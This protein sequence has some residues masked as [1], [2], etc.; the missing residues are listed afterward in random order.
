MPLG[1]GPRVHLPYV[2]TIRRG[3]QDGM[4]PR[5]NMLPLGPP[6]SS[7]EHQITHKCTGFT[8]QKI[9]NVL[10]NVLIYRLGQDVQVKALHG[11]PLWIFLWC[12]VLLNVFTE[13]LPRRKGTIREN[14][15]LCKK[16]FLWN[17]NLFFLSGEKSICSVIFFPKYHKMK[18]DHQRWK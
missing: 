12:F 1:V 5:H 18:Q 11:D 8:S 9:H 13:F 7:S 3:W 17:P 6:S 16:W 15:I 4:H 14:P 10:S 2:S